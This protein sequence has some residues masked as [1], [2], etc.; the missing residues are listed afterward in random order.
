[1]PIGVREA[2]LTL[3]VRLVADEHRQRSGREQQLLERVENVFRVEHRADAVEGRR[4][5]DE[6]K[7]FENRL[8]AD[9]VGKPRRHREGERMRLPQDV[10][11]DPDVP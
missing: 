6:M 3:D 11:R 7:L 4:G 10:V 8:R 9:A 5:V 2:V 1:M